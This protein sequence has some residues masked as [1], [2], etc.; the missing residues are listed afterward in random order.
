MISVSLS[1]VP[2]INKTILNCDDVASRTYGFET[3][4]SGVS[5]EVA[6]TAATFRA[7]A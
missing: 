3:Q 7:T 6:T 4:T 1:Y 5:Y 2:A